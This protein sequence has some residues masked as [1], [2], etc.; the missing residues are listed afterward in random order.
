MKKCDFFKLIKINGKKIL[1]ITDEECCITFETWNDNFDQI[2]KFV[3]KFC[4]Q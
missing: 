1:V 4:I 3:K 2:K